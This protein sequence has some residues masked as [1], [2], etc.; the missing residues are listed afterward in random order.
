MK[1]WLF[2]H[3]AR[4]LW[5]AVAAG[6][7]YGLAA[8]L[9]FYGA[10][11]AWE[12]LFTT[13][14]CGFIF[15]MPAAL[16]Y[17]TVRFL[18]APRLWQR[19][20]L[21]WLPGLILVATAF[22]VGWEGSICIVMA[23]PAFMVMGSIGGLLE[24]RARDRLSDRNQMSALLGM[25]LLPYAV[26]PLEQLNGLPAQ[27]R[28]VETQIM[29]NADVETVWQQIIRVPAITVDEQRF[30]LVHLIGIPKP[31]AAT[32]SHEGVGGV[33]HATFEHGVTFVE[34]I[35]EWQPHQSLAFTIDALAETMAVEDLN[36]K[37]VVGGAYFDTLDGRYELEPLTDGRV[38]LHLSSEHRLSTRFNFYAGW[39]TDWVMRSTQNYIL[40]VIKARCE[41]GG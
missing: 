39:W 19:I 35:N 20:V 26:A 31:V 1:N 3:K 33:R 22:A 38:V 16:G 15:L 40:D 25:L 9:A 28:T 12:N 21:P 14:T 13:M 5:L 37:V 29:I 27:V 17:L 36:A 2:S 8:R 7:L 6:V 4:G 11:P 10:N 23:L 18:H 32:L 41:A 34:T 24:Q 30:N